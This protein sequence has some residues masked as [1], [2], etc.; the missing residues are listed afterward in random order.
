M[1]GKSFPFSHCGAPPAPASNPSPPRSKL[2]CTRQHSRQPT[3]CIAKR[4]PDKCNAPHLLRFDPPALVLRRIPFNTWRLHLSHSSAVRAMHAA[5]G[6]SAFRLQCSAV[7][8]WL[9]GRLQ[10]VS[11]PAVQDFLAHNLRHTQHPH[12]MRVPPQLCF[13]PPTNAPSC[14]GWHHWFTHG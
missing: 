14:T 13:Q 9:S 12:H 2:P 1:T 7:L 3:C 10:G 8:L 6:L 11:A 4:M 5:R